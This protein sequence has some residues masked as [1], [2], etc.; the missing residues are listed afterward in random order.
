MIVC[1]KG[2]KTGALYYV[3]K[4]TNLL[5]EKRSNSSVKA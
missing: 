2:L 5:G 1:I 3:Y 4:Y